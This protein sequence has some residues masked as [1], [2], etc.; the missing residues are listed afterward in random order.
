MLGVNELISQFMYQLILVI[1]SSVDLVKFDNNW[2]LFLEAIEEMPGLISESFTR[3]DRHIYGQSTIS[4]IYSFCFKDQETLE[5]SLV[6]MPGE[7]AGK[8]IHDLTEG[9]VILLTGEL[10]EDSID[11]IK[12]HRKPR[13]KK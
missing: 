1:P 12:S 7:K 11:N 13:S 10:R 8:I 2:P 9:Q 3:I 4:R 5:N 6:S